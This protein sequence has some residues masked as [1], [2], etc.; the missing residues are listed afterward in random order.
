MILDLGVGNRDNL[1]VCGVLIFAGLVL[2]GVSGTALATR[3][4]DGEKCGPANFRVGVGSFEAATAN[5]SMIAF[6]VFVLLS[7]FL[8]LLWG[9][10][11]PFYAW[12]LKKE[13]PA[14][15]PA[16]FMQRSACTFVVAAILLWAAVFVGLVI[17]SGLDSLCTEHHCGIVN[18]TGVDVFITASDGSQCYVDAM[19][20]QEACTTPDVCCGCKE[21]W[22]S[23]RSIS[24]VCKTTQEWACGAAITEKVLGFSVLV[25]ALLLS[26]AAGILTA[27]SRGYLTAIK[28]IETVP[29]TSAGDPESPKDDGP[30][31]TGA[32]LVE[33]TQVPAQKPRSELQETSPS[34]F[35]SLPSSKPPPPLGDGGA[36]LVDDDSEGGLRDVGAATPAGGMTSSM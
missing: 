32:T 25:Y 27:V 34:K 30:A 18:R 16:P 26:V 3:V 9:A 35:A 2:V 5:A 19:V 21:S 1:V 31:P 17:D 12:K 28:I 7:A 10:R 14:H 23:Q 11:G 15:E 36:E 13:G 24:Y 33:D 22:Q 6:G 4:P 8:Q 29:E 20:E